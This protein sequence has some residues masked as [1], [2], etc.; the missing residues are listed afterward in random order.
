MAILL[1]TAPK[2]IMSA[3]TSSGVGAVPVGV[4]GATVAVRVT[5]PPL[6]IVDC[7]VTR[8]VVVGAGALT[9]S[10][11]AAQVRRSP[12]AVY[13]MLSRVHRSLR[14]CVARELDVFESVAGRAVL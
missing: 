11:I 6:C 1:P 7:E 2:D 5:E 12:D 8:V 4:T 13:Q 3:L 10:V 9:V 14:E